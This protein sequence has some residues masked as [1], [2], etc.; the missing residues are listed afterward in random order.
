MNR[1]IEDSQIKADAIQIINCTAKP[2]LKSRNQKLFEVIGTVL[3]VA[4]VAV[5][6]LTFFNRSLEPNTPAV[7]TIGTETPP[8]ETTPE[9]DLSAIEPPSDNEEQDA[10][11]EKVALE[12]LAA[13]ASEATEKEREEEEIIPVKSDDKSDGESKEKSQ[14]AEEPQIKAE[15]PSQALV[16]QPEETSK[17]ERKPDANGYIYTEEEAVEFLRTEFQKIIN[18]NGSAYIDARDAAL[19][20]GYS[21]PEEF[22]ADIEQLLTNPYSS[23]KLARALDEYRRLGNEGVL[24]GKASLWLAAGG[25]DAKWVE[26]VTQ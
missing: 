20:K 14:R 2:Q 24:I 15:S 11:E 26:S 1:H 25:D 4:L 10:S 9:E 13:L 5:G 7:D 23:E 19:G 21:T 18:E 3:V 12:P 22:E 17:E 16:S 8:P 6:G